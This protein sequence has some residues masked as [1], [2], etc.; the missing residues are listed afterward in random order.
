MTQP[1]ANATSSTRKVP[2][3]KQAPAEVTPINTAKKAVAETAAHPPA[4]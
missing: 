4:S 3:K 2:A 1:Q